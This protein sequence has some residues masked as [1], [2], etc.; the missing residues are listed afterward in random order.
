MK[1]NKIIEHK[2][3]VI[4]AA[5]IGNYDAFIHVA[6]CENV[7]GGGLA[8]QVRHRIPSLYKAD[9][10]YWIPSDYRLGLF[11]RSHFSETTVGFNLY[12][13]QIPDSSSRQ[14]NYGSLVN[15][16]SES[17]DYMI[18]NGIVCENIIK[19]CLPKLMGCGLAG[20]D[21]KIVK[22]LLQY[23]HFD[24]TVEFHTYEF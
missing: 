21:W 4:E 1:T 16:L 14:L 8:L 15:S 11:S 22:E 19:V 12:A 2:G 18:Q 6:N 20:G 9:C 5:L 23:T 3:D 24:C 17:I 10:D 13:Q 7:M